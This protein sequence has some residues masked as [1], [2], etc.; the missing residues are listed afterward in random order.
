[1][2]QSI[3]KFLVRRGTDTERQQIVL[4]NGELGATNDN[5]SHRLFVGDG[6]KVGGWPVASKL[7]IMVNFGDPYTGNFVQTGDFVYLTST[8]KL[9]ALTAS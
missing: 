3:I 9:Y 1:M 2:A 4:A 6:A 5:N 7:F 8:T